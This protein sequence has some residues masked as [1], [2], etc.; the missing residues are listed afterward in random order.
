[1]QLITHT[2]AFKRRVP[3]ISPLQRRDALDVL[4]PYLTAGR[5]AGRSCFIYLFLILPQVECQMNVSEVVVFHDTPLCDGVWPAVSIIPAARITLSLFDPSCSSSIHFLFCLHEYVWTLH[6][7]IIQ[8]SCFSLQLS[9]VPPLLGND[10]IPFSLAEANWVWLLGLVEPSF[11]WGHKKMQIKTPCMSDIAVKIMLV[12]TVKIT[13]LRLKWWFYLKNR[14]FY[15][16]W[17]NYTLLFRENLQNYVFIAFEIWIFHSVSSQC[18][19]SDDSKLLLKLLEL[20]IS[21][22]KK[23]IAYCHFHIF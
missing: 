17:K 19:C 23:S 5:R 6:L 12:S 16:T 11:T 20:K 7:P 14:G 1:M 21:K 4:K 2:A 10:V 18:L 22:I 13:R 8:N 9:A 3:Q 15:F